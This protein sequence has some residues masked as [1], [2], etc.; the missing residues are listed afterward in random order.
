[1]KTC[2]TCRKWYPVD[3]G[4]KLGMCY[5]STEFLTNSHETCGRWEREETAEEAADA[6]EGGG[7]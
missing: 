2:Q 6:A 3:E 5:A 4:S 1:M 7:S